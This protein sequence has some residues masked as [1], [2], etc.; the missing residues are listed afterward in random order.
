MPGWSVQSDEAISQIR[1]KPH[2]CMASPSGLQSFTGKALDIPCKVTVL[3][4]PRITVVV[5]F[6]RTPMRSIAC[7]SFLPLQSSFMVF[8][9]IPNR[10]LGGPWARWLG[11]REP[12]DRI[13]RSLVGGN[14]STHSARQE[15]LF[16]ARLEWFTPV[17]LRSANTCGPFIRQI[18]SWCSCLGWFCR[19]FLI[20]VLNGYCCVSLQASLGRMSR[21]RCVPSAGL[22]PVFV[23][24]GVFPKIRGS[25]LWTLSEFRDRQD[26]AYLLGVP[27][28]SIGT[29]SC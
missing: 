28:V 1:Q 4:R 19:L 11:G 22:Y 10:P 9:A 25:S 27:C 16:V 5:L 23:I 3:C 29:S 14:G 6:P 15:I 13:V 2:A 18:G 20:G 7:I 12:C 8:A 21:R 17:E 24:R 26:C